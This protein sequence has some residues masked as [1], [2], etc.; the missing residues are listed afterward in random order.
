MSIFSFGKSFVAKYPC[1]LKIA[2]FG[3]NL[4][5]FN[6]IK[7]GFRKNKIV[8]NTAFMSHCKIKIKGIGNKII[9]GDKVLL[10]NCSIYI[11]GNNNLI[12]LSDMV[13]VHNGKF[14]IEDN[15][16]L[17][18]MGKKS[19]ICDPADF[20]AIEGTAIK[21]GEECLVSSDTFFRTGDSHSILDLEGNR[22]NLSQDIN[23]GNRIWVCHRASILK[24]V[25]I[26]DDTVISAGAIVTKS[27]GESNT[28]LAGSP[29]RVIKNGYKWI[30][31]RV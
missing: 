30:R 15:G 11:N 12:D 3:Y 4:I 9:L 22:V 1:F 14:H 29:A 28:I 5:S 21:I 24:G 23:F 16:N 19:L 31:E 20:S 27:F 10:K 8:R 17:I 2:S 13:C 7:I 18:N 26:A 6:S 25:T